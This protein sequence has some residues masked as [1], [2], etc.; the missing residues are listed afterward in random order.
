MSCNLHIA[1]SGIFVFFDLWSCELGVGCKVEICFL[2]GNLKLEIVVGRVPTLSRVIFKLEIVVG[3]VSTLS[4]VIFK[5]EIVV[6]RVSTLSGVIFKLEIVVGQVS[7]LYLPSR[8]SFN[9]FFISLFINSFNAL[10]FYFSNFNIG[11]FY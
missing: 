9:H 2:Q 4:R 8:D 7:T 10:S 3:R 6:G 5:L 11:V 1:K